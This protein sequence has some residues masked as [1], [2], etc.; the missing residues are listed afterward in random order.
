MTVAFANAASVHKCADLKSVEEV[1]DFALNVN[2]DLC[3]RNY[4]AMVHLSPF[5]SNLF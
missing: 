5:Y 1:I 2:V 4:F 3:L